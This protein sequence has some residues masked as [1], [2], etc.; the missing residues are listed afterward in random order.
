MLIERNRMQ[1]FFQNCCFSKQQQN[2]N[3]STR[4]TFVEEPARDMQPKL[5]CT[6]TVPSDNTLPSSFIVFRTRPSSPMERLKALSA[7]L[8]NLVLGLLILSGLLREK[9]YSELQEQNAIMGEGARRWLC[10]QG[11]SIDTQL[12]TSVQLKQEEIV[13]LTALAQPQESEEKKCSEQAPKKGL[14]W[15]LNNHEEI[16]EQQA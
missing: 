15:L 7:L 5:S 12:S 14:T 9:P 6:I 13:K 1:E 16:L 11:I 4:L 10:L 3:K 2:T 8:I